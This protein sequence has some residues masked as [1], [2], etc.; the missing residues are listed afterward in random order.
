MCPW[1]ARWLGLGGEA[2]TLLVRQMQPAV[3]E[4]FAQDAVLLAQIVHDLGLLAVHEAGEQHEHEAQRKE[5]VS[6]DGAVP[7]DRV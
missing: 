4:L 6:H 2:S 5:G 3:A 7:I 1:P